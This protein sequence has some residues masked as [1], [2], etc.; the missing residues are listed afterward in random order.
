[1]DSAAFA[2]LERTLADQ[3]ADAALDRLCDRLRDEGDYAG[4]FYAL[5]MKKRHQL[6]INP[7]PT[8]PAHDLPEKHHAEYEEAIRQAGRQVGKLFLDNGNLPQAWAYYRMI[9]EPEPVKAVLDAY[10]AGEEEYVQPLVQVAFYEGVH[11]RRGFD[12]ILQASASARPSPHS[13]GRRGTLGRRPRPLHPHAR[14][15]AVP[16]AARAADGR[17]RN[18]RGEGPAGSGLA[19]G[20]RRMLCKLLAG[21]DWL[22]ADDFYHIDVSHLSSVV[23]MSVNLSPCPELELARELCEYGQRL[24]GRFQSGG[25]PPFANQYEA[26]GKYLAVLAGDNVEDGLAYFR[27]QVEDNNPEEVGTYPAEIYVNLLLKAGRDKE[28]LAVARKYLGNTDG[29]RLTCPSVAVCA[30]DGRFPHAGRGG[31][32]AE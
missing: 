23:Q 27:K 5:L 32:R 13:A 21:R 11:P 22:F 7:I 20:R 24:S 18:S 9:G 16:R 3:G 15:G 30:E 6:G 10:Q 26:F 25:E 4:L 2:E 17:H 8:G 28:A 29:R 1:M 19:A 14:P 31:P 12:W